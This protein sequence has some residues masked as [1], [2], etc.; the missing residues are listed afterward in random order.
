[1]VEW[2]L[3]PVGIFLD[4][5]TYTVTFDNYPSQYT[6]WILIADLKNDTSLTEIIHTVMSGI[7]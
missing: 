4:G 5:V 3:N 7:T 6:R 2:N 1:M